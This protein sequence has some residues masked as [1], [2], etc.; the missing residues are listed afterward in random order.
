MKKE[1]PTPSNSVTGVTNVT[2]SLPK[3]P[4]PFCGD[5]YKT[6]IDF[7]MELHIYENHRHKL[8][9]LQIEGSLDKKIEY[10]IAESKEQVKK[11]TTGDDEIGDN[12]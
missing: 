5:N 12:R 2:A 7:D 11:D 4:C 6:H 9:T 1:T 8:V 10:L 3:Y